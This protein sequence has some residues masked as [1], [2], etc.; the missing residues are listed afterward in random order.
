MEIKLSQRSEEDLEQRLTLG[1]GSL[2][3]QRP[4]T[5][6]RKW[7]RDRCLYNSTTERGT[8]RGRPGVQRESAGIGVIPAGEQGLH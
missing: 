4:E 3:L 8:N 7:G 5:K 6:P 2:L 1:G